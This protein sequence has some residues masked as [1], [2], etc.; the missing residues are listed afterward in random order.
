MGDIVVKTSHRFRAELYSAIV[1]EAIQD[2]LDLNNEIYIEEES[3][4]GWVISRVIE[5]NED[6]NL[7]TRPD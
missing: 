5:L 7:T 3:T 6:L 2:I 1:E 4:L